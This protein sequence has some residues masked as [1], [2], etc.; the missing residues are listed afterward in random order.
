MT[1]VI[2]L[3]F[4]DHGKIISLLQQ[5]QKLSDILTRDRPDPYF[6]TLRVLMN[7]LSVKEAI[8][9]CNDVHQSFLVLWKDSLKEL[10]YPFLLF[11]FSFFMIL[12]FDDYILP[13][14]ASFTGTPHNAFIFFLKIFY[15]LLFLFVLIT[16]IFVFYIKQSSIEKKR[17][18]IASISKS[19]L[20]RQISSL[21]FSRILQSLLNKGISTQ[22]CFEIMDTMDF[23][24][25]IHCS[26]G[27]ILSSLKKGKT[28][29]Q[30]FGSCP[31]F[32]SVFIRLTRLGLY[33]A[34]LEPILELYNQMTMN[35]VKNQIHR[36][37]IWIQAFSYT[38][39]GVVVLVVYQ[40]LL[41]PLEMLKTI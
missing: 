36:I 14:M 28:P 9:T 19:V 11:L 5:G 12:F 22:E 26:A 17:K 18:W 15:I 1:T 32:D 40:V 29:E 16:L 38:G 31:Y 24:P 25:I 34:S 8:L 23:N 4:K 7:H 41:M 37:C 10:F 35:K 3:V 39:V 2:E 21:Q 13:Q 27:Y 33:S 30:A 20:F 6:R